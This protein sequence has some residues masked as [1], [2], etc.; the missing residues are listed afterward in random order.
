L[1]SGRR[2]DLR[3]GFSA[4]AQVTEMATAKSLRH[5]A[6]ALEGTTEAAHRDRTA[7]KVARIFVTVAA[8]GLT[9]N[10]KFAPDE[11]ALK[12]TLLPDAFAPVDNAW[13][14]QGWT[15]ALLSQLTDQDLASA[16]EL[17]WTHAVPKKPTAA[18]RKRR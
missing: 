16:L 8:D 5:M 2:Y 13:G 11:Q 6:L 17:A 4:I 15:A 18:G 12:C 7:F 9:A 1:R 10:F 3:Y 14:A